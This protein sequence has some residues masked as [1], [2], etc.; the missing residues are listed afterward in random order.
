[1]CRKRRRRTADDESPE[2]YERPIQIEPFSNVSK[3]ERLLVGETFQ[4]GVGQKW[5]Y[6]DLVN[7]NLFGTVKK[8]QENV[9]E[10][11]EG[12]KELSGELAEK[13]ND[14]REA[15]TKE[16]FP[17]TVEENAPYK[18]TNQRKS[19]NDRQGLEK[20]SHSACQIV[21]NVP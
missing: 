19:K 5:R 11:L 9:F 2:G 7:G 6:V 20:K 12:G 16:P 1:L 10:I 3:R 8:C 4:Y 13:G 17:R 18:K 14:N 21:N 15:T